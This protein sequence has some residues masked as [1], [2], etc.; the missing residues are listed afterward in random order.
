MAAARS[1]TCAGNGDILWRFRFARK[2]QQTSFRRSPHVYLFEL[3][4]IP[5]TSAQ[6]NRYS[7]LGRQLLGSTAQRVFHQRIAADPGNQRKMPIRISQFEKSLRRIREAQRRSLLPH[8][9]LCVEFPSQSS[10]KVVRPSQRT[11]PTSPQFSPWQSAH[12]VHRKDSHSEERARK[13][14]LGTVRPPAPAPS[15]CWQGQKAGPQST[16]WSIVIR[17]LTH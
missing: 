2:N 13:R 17:S 4:K 8:L 7:Q 16:C 1:P 14:P 12:P 10:S 5:R 15:T 11:T 3:T 9:T 6:Q